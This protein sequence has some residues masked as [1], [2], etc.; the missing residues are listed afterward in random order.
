MYLIGVDVGGTGSKEV[1]ADSFSTWTP[2]LFFGKG[3]GDLPETLPWLRPLAITGL[4]FIGI[5][6][7]VG[8]RLSHP[9][10]R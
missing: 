6:A 3:F 5:A 4:V 2:G 9:R 1:G 10:Q 7:L 8:Y